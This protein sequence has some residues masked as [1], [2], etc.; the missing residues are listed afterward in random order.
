MPILLKMWALFKCTVL[1]NSHLRASHVQT[2]NN[3][4]PMEQLKIVCLQIIRIVPYRA[5]SQKYSTSSDFSQCVGE[6]QNAWDLM[7]LCI[8]NSSFKSPCKGNGQ[9]YRNSPMRVQKL[10]LKNAG[11]SIF[12]EYSVTILTQTPRLRNVNVK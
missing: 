1:F 9:T 12:I 8:L 11:I 6:K 5:R 3:N 2:P 7:Y 10:L 4:W